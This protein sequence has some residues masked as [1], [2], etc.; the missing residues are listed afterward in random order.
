MDE[1]CVEF[2][3]G[4]A[5]FSVAEAGQRLGMGASQ[6]ATIRQHRSSLPGRGPANE[7]GYNGLL[8]GPSVP[9]GAAAG[10]AGPLFTATAASMNYGWF[11]WILLPG[12]FIPGVLIA[13][14]GS[15]QSGRAL[16]LLA[17]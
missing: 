2:V 1:Y 12:T 4:R 15:R 13:I 3:V 9:H 8:E 17:E 14:F 10:R 16:E 5:A 6:R 7:A 11:I